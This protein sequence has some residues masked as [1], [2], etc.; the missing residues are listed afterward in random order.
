MRRKGTIQVRKTDSLADYESKTV[1]PRKKKRNR[2][3]DLAPE[4]VSSHNF[5]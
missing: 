5:E 4:A 3:K 2:Q 1:V